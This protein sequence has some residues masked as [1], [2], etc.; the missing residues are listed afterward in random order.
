MNTEVPAPR[1][2]AGRPALPLPA[3]DASSTRS[4]K[5]PAP[6]PWPRGAPGARSVPFP[7]VGHIRG[8]SWSP[9][10]MAPSWRSRAPGPQRELRAE[11]SPGRR[12]LRVMLLP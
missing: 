4:W 11:G 9:G 1:Q 10:E 6:P 3:L 12:W 8:V 2:P 7:K 5:W